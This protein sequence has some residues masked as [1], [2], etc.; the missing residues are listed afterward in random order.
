MTSPEATIFTT[1]DESGDPATVPMELS[2]CRVTTPFR[3]TQLTSPGS[4][5]G[6]PLSHRSHLSVQ[7]SGEFTELM[8]ASSSFR[9]AVA[10]EVESQLEDLLICLGQEE[11]K[12]QILSKIV[13]E[14]GYSPTALLKEH[15][16]D[17]QS[18]MNQIS[19]VSA[20][21]DAD[22]AAPPGS[23]VVS[24]YKAS[25]PAVV[26]AL[27]GQKR[28]GSPTSVFDEISHDSPDSKASVSPQR[29][30]KT[31][32]KHS[33]HITPQAVALKSLGYMGWVLLGMSKLSKA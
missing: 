16:L 5:L 9:N 32:E 23:I 27:P 31:S 14:L 15:G 12:V 28:G 33:K 4:H 7:S 19:D 10:A 29:A 22:E 11:Q 20:D 24:P 1:R 13:Q 18:L 6:T 21:A 30:P 26:G 3:Q 8:R 17:E 2:P 25:T